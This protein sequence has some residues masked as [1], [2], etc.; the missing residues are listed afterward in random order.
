MTMNASYGAKRN[1]NDSFVPVIIFSLSFHLV[2]FL[3]VPLLTKLFRRPPTFERPQ[4]FQL[5]RP[6]IPQP[7]APTPPKPVEKPKPKPQ[8]KPQQVA[9][10][11]P[12]PKPVHKPKQPAPAKEKKPEPENT[13]ELAELLQEVPVPAQ[14][15]SV[16]QS[17]KYHWYLNSVQQ[18]IERQWKPPS[19]KDNASV[20]VTF[21]IF[22]NGTIS[23]AKVADPSGSSVLDN[24]AIRAVSLAAPFGKLPPGFSGDKLNLNCTLRPVRR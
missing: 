13:D 1:A 17:F 8:P 10:P 20:T 15:S 3:I 18:Q 23:N 9:K 6:N 16:S 11:T 5:V 22:S 21:T 7:P 2:V 4:T 12:K 14:L 24:L 19:E